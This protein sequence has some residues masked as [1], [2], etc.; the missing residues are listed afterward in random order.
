MTLLVAQKKLKVKQINQLVTLFLVKKFQ[1][2]KKE[3]NK[4]L[5]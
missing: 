3:P 2:T 5:H 4:K 1:L